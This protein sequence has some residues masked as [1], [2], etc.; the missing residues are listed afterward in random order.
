MQQKRSKMQ[1]NHTEKPIGSTLL[2]IAAFALFTF[3]GCFTTQR[4]GQVFLSTLEDFDRVARPPTGERGFLALF[5]PFIYT[6]AFIGMFSLGPVS[7]ILYFP[8][9]IWL[10]VNEGTDIVVLDDNMRPIEDAHV[11]VCYRGACLSGNG[12]TNQDGVFHTG[13]KF[14]M[15]DFGN[16]SVRKEGYYPSIWFWRPSGGECSPLGNFNVQTTVLSKV[17]HPIQLKFRKV[18]L[19]ECA[20]VIWKESE[21]GKWQA[22]RKFDDMIKYDFVVGDWMPPYGCGKMA[23]AT[24]YLTTGNENGKM[25]A[26]VIFNGNGNGVIRSCVRHRTGVLMKT[27]PTD[28]YESDYV[29]VGRKK[30]D[31]TGLYFRIRGNLY[32]KI[33][34][35]FFIDECRQNE[36]LEIKSGRVTWDIPH[37]RWSKKTTF[38]YYLNTTPNDRNLE[39]M[40][41]KDHWRY[42]RS[43]E[44]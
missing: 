11:T 13:I 19:L 42:G 4:N 35:D 5:D 16:I 36:E 6:G 26:R 18:R 12:K 34:R 7:D 39:Q 37:G 44:P 1:S 24:F 17:E 2:I 28:G 31:Q 29:S 9:D 20:N 27:A 38:Q 15:I 41:E 25:S 21:G 33:C 14:P 30:D 32:G 8:Y 23:D 40:R 10:S 22:I 3:C 43:Y